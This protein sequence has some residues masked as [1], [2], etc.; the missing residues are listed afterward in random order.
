MGRTSDARERL[1]QSAI[2]LIYARS[3]GAVGVQA[4]CEQAGVKKGSFYHFFPSKRDLTLA[5]AEALAQRLDN[6]VLDPAFTPDIPPLERIARFFERGAMLQEEYRQLTGTVLGCPLGNLATEM[7]TQDEILRLRLDQLFQGAERKIEATLAEALEDGSAPGID[8]AAGARAI[9]AYMEGLLLMAKA[10]NDT[11]CIRELG[12]A[13][14]GLVFAQA[15]PTQTA[16]PV[17]DTG[18]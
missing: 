4:I 6:K 3:Y 13:A 5:A 8:P 9:F 1:I 14:A 17:T 10:R 12:R 7:S 16:A 2:D 18:G 15:Q 11:T